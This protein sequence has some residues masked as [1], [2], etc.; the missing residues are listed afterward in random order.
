[1]EAQTTPQPSFEEWT[2]VFTGSGKGQ[3]QE[4]SPT[5]IWDLIQQ[6]HSFD[7]TVASGGNS[8][9]VSQLLRHPIPERMVDF[10][11]VI[12]PKLKISKKNNAAESLESPFDMNFEPKLLD[13]YPKYRTDVSFPDGIPIFCLPNGCN[14]TTGSNETKLATFVLTA[15]TGYRLYGTVL[16]TREPLDLKVLRSAFKERKIPLP[17]W[18]SKKEIYKTTYFVP[19]CLVVLSHHAY[20]AVQRTFLQQLYR[21]SLSGQSPLPLE[22]YVASFVHDVPLPPK[23]ST[24]V[25][26]NAFTNDTTVEF[27]RPAPNDLPLVNFSY[28]P[29]LRCLSVSNILTLWGILLQEG[30][31]VLRTV[32]MALL[33]P[34][35]EAL[36]SLL[37]PLTWHGTFIPVL[38]SSM[39]DV[40]DAP[41]P[42]LVGVVGTSCP[43][44]NGVVVCDL[45]Q[46]IV[47]L[48][49]D[50]HHNQAAR[51]LPQLP[52]TQTMTLKRELEDIADS[53]YL[54]PPCG[55]KGRITTGD[56][57]LLDNS[58]REPYAHQTQ[59]REVSMTNTHRHF[60]L[61]SAE[62]VPKPKTQLTTDDFLQG[63]EQT[64]YMSPEDEDHCGEEKKHDKHD[65]VA[66]HSESVANAFRR[67]GRAVQ[68]GTGLLLSFTSLGSNLYDKE[69]EKKKYDI[70]DGLYDVDEKLA[71]KIRRKFLKFFST[72]LVR[73]KEFSNKGSFKYEW[74][75]NQLDMPDT[76]RAYVKSITTTQMFERFLVESSTRRR[77]FDELVVLQQN[78]QLN[79][80]LSKK[81][82]T[83]FL[84]EHFP[85]KK[86]LVPAAPCNVGVRP[87]SLFVYDR[88]PRLD[89]DEMV[90][91]KTLD[92][93][94]AL[95]HFGSEIFCGW[96]T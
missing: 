34:I 96:S 60:I 33:T 75:C 58:V 62:F 61:Y 21:I 4:S 65:Y 76:N 29:L 2:S 11:C 24:G 31:V 84:D 23:P 70:A 56:H 64:K 68:E 25:T 72:L 13:C 26:W 77:L 90:A 47:H 37:F 92:P 57:D 14:L 95:C 86:V 66:S 22:R 45:D 19:K 81:K 41:V 40:F 8:S 43:Q 91:N 32:N 6:S 5:G 7:G 10:F 88:F 48:G 1:M 71:R 85:L 67:H 94:S 80:V 89:F 49:W 44:P 73:Y 59:L 83:P 9:I 82:E 36:I 15:S 35:A 69:M 78:N 28:R 50:D 20:Y 27:R 18:L 55:I 87:G 12:G 16:T 51:A 79:S 54:I 93:V 38:P 3:E 53:M 74:F 52:P 30:R 63:E 39:V 17:K 42:F 46:D